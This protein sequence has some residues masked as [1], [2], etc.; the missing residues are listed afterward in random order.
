MKLFNRNW[1]RKLISGLSFTSALFIFQACYGTA[2]DFEADILVE[3][4]VKSKTTGEPINGIKVTVGENMQYEFT[5][6]EGKFLFY[7]MLTD[8]INFKFD[9]IDSISNGS[10]ISKDTIVTEV[11]DSVYLDILLEDK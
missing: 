1:V 5:N 8:T 6:A 7:T 4:Q 11:M 10:F 3:G 9:D 2:Q